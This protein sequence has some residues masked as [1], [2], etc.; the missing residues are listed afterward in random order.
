MPGGVAC[1]GWQVARARSGTPAMVA[2]GPKELP[3]ALRALGQWMGKIRRMASEF[4][5]QF[6]EAMREA[7]LAELKKEVDEMASK[8]ASYTQYDPVSEITRDIEKAAG[9]LPSLDASPAGASSATPPNLAPSGTDAVT[10]APP[11]AAADASAAA[12][13]VPP[14]VPAEPAAAPA[15]PP[16]APSSPPTADA[17]PP[18]PEPGRAA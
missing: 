9:P 3:G 16:S 15:S 14:P 8:A 2:I 17:A 13:E 11:P 6:N 4:Q 10:A 5:N 7:E 12:G 18:K 1:H